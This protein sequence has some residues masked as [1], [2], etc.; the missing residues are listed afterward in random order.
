MAVTYPN[1]ARRKSGEI[2]AFWG[3]S[4]ATLL[5][6]S[7]RTIMALGFGGAAIGLVLGL[8][9]PRTYTS[10]A[11]FVPQTNEANAS[12]L[13]LAASQMG[14]RLP[15][16][17]S[18]WGPAVYVELLRSWA[19]LE[20]LARET[21][22][23]PEEGDKRIPLMDL[24]KV[25]ASNPQ[26]RLELTVRRLSSIISAREVKALGG[27]ELRVTTKWP[28]VSFAIAQ[29]LVDGV[30]RFNLEKRK[31]Q[32]T[33]ERQ[34][35]E[36]QTTD[37]E[38]ALRDAED[39]LQEFLQRNR[40]TTSISSEVAFQK[41]RLQREVGLR[42]QLYTTLAQ[43]R[44]E[45]RSR[46]VRDTPVITVLEEP[47]LPVVPESRRVALKTVLGGLLGGLVGMLIAFL[48]QGLAGA[49]KTPDETAQEFF[50]LMEEATPRILR[51]KK[52]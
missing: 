45:A 29:Q 50:R 28:S 13:A 17:N 8:L 6:R 23:V 47:R 25:K 11:T 38:R 27:V 49:R 35:V 15:T 40:M 2:E 12:A 51:R 37:A 48:S 1:F 21:M 19:L 46:E 18:S 52:G 26:R 20:P 36:A 34:F 14:V 24:L 9:T 16:Q 22:V 4:I 33:A 30:N 7:R 3:L 41:D 32:A 42:Q 44:A 5:L 43:S 10:G 31:S 39:Q